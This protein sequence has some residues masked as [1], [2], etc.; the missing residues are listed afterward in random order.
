MCM[1]QSLHRGV[2]WNQYDVVLY[3]MWPYA[4]Y[5]THW[6]IQIFFALMSSS[7]PPI[8][9]AHH[10]SS[11]HF[12]S[13][14]LPLS[15][16]C[17]TNNWQIYNAMKVDIV[18]Y[19]FI[20]QTQSSV[21]WSP[22]SPSSWRASG[23]KSDHVISFNMYPIL[24]SVVL[25]VSCVLYCWHL[26]QLLEFVRLD[27]IGCMKPHMWDINGLKVRQG[28]VIKVFHQSKAVL[29]IKLNLMSSL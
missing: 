5:I 20:W 2:Y 28:G 13:P 17:K 4:L 3:K 27:L 11:Q 21:I 15:P 8:L 7:F 6:A 19:W 22:L 18:S 29:G 1:G 25:M 12:S 24:Q 26:Q 23:C 16:D 14:H 9:N 10:N